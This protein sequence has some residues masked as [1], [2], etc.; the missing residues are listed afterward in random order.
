MTLCLYLLRHG[1]TTYSQTGGYCGDLDPPLTP[2]GEEMAQSVAAAYQQVKW[3]GVYVSPKQ[4]AIATAKP[5]CDALG[6]KMEL[7]PGLQEI[8]YGAWENRT[9]AEV[10]AEYAEDYQHWLAEPSWNPPTG[11]ETGVEVATRATGVI[12]EIQHAHPTGNVLIVSHK[13]TIRILLCS[14][15]GIDLGR[16]RDRLDIPTASMS[17]IEFAKYGPRLLSAGDRSHLSPELRSRGGT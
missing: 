2:A 11:G 1:E 5:L 13:A 10:M 16:Y 12:S 9:N 3:A 6:L 14:F 4:R 15:L 17:K 8:A 7:R